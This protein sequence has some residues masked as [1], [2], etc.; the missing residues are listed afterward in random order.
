MFK[1]DRKFETVKKQ[2]Q[3]IHVPLYLLKLLAC[4]RVKSGSDYSVPVNKETP[5]FS[6]ST[7]QNIPLTHESELLFNKL[8]NIP[9]I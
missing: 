7:Q 5:D 4:K 3:K 2:T 9:K 6:Q 1:V 8:W